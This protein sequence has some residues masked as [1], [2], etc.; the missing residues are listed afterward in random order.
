M[1]KNTT[2]THSTSRRQ[3][4]QTSAA[5]SAGLIVGFH[6][7]AVSA[8]VLA[9]ANMNGAAEIN[10]WIHITPDNRTILK[11]ARSE[12][13]QG[14]STA[15]PQLLAEELECDWSRVEL[16]EALFSEHLARNRVYVSTSTGGSR[17]VRDSQAYLLKAGATARVM[18]IQAA[19]E[20]WGVPASEC[21]A[22]N[23]VITHGAS[24]RTLEYG[25]VAATAA[26][27]K[28]PESVT[29]KDAKDWKILG[30]AVPRFDIPD[31]VIGKPMYGI[32][33]VRPGMVHAA[34]AQC[35]VFGGKTKSIDAASLAAAK[36]MRGI[37]EVL[38]MGGYVAVT[39]NNWWRCNQAVKS[40]KIEWDVGDSSN[41]SSASIKTYLSEG[42]TKSGAVGKSVGD[43]AATY[44]AAPVKLEAEYYVPYLDHAPM[45]PMNCTAEVKDGR[46]TVWVP[47]QS[48]EGSAAAAAGAADVAPEKVQ[49]FRQQLGGGFGR[50][51]AFQDFTR[52][53]VEIAKKTGKTVKLLWSREEDIQHGHYRP[54]TL[55]KV[56]GA[57]DKD[58]KLVALSGRVAVQ[59][60]LERV[61]PEALRQT[62]DGPLDPQATTSF[63]DTAYDVPNLRAEHVYRK[64]HVPVGFWRSVSH[65]QNPMFRECFL[66]ELLAKSPASNRDPYQFRRAMLQ[67][68]SDAARRD[69]GVLDAVAKAADWTKPLPANT[70]RGIAVQDAYGSHAASVVE[71]EK[72]SD[73]K[74][75]IKRVVIVVDS[76]HVANEGAAKAQIEGCVIY[77][78]TAVLYGEITIK[79]GRVEQSNFNDYPMMKIN[80]TPEIVS[81]LAPT[82]GF[83]GGMGEPPMAPLVPAFLNAIFAATGT[84]IRS[85]PLKH[86]GLTFV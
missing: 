43:F 60:I 21:S 80:E 30:K 83:W 12:M 49:V 66:D 54:A 58:G 19:A 51:G 37:D 15:L 47:T 73:G 10:A 35:P 34:I 23:S 77:G 76:G 74:L 56:Q 86:S 67:G 16:S 36:K 48:A 62:P 22:A 39:G 24:K 29:L 55:A 82:G 41:V 14:A 68:V 75:K 20:K 45:E 52:Q 11:F 8:Q 79:N 28:A 2:S 31:K 33:V 6:W 3:F 84:P 70:Y 53:A 69:L 13:G 1:M 85:L 72:R 40:L 61:R 44:A 81:I 25:D 18:L 27:L 59:S 63:E 9:P 4:L 26:K 32:D 38:D 64:T 17:G 71:I 78:L 42:L 7:P 65:S 57:L 5:T 50:R 46:V